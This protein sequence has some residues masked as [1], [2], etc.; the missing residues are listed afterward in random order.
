MTY[1]E[2]CQTKLTR[3]RIMGLKKRYPEFFEE[4]QKK[5]PNLPISEAI[6]KYFFPSSGKC[7]V[8]GK[9]TSY[10]GIIRGYSP[11]CSNSCSRKD[12]ES[13]ERRKNTSMKRYGVPIPSQSKIVQQKMEDTCMKRY[14]V[15]RVMESEEFIK[16]TKSN[17][18]KKYG[19]ESPSSLPHIKKKVEETNLKR[20]GVK[21]PILNEEIKNKIIKTTTERYGGMGNSS[22]IIRSRYENTCLCRYGSP[23]PGGL[24]DQQEKV[25]QTKLKRYGVPAYLP[26]SQISQ[27]FFKEIDDIF[28]KKY[29]TEFGDKNQEHH[30]YID[31][32][33]Y[34][35]DYYVQELNLDIEFQ[36]DVWHGNPEIFEPDDHCIPT[37]KSL[38]AKDL[39]Q[40]DQERMDKLKSIGITTIV[41]WESEYKKCKDFKQLIL[42]KL[43]QQNILI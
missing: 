27:K 1:Q 37:C 42:N 9:Q 7:K 31:G 41:V 4:L 21:V 40:K 24:P 15:K 28:N 11:Y 34:Y 12:P 43:K 17:N 3:T 13:E 36:G 38:T 18:L 5:F 29:H 25:K 30:I 39:W 20:Y 2:I 22:D 6:Y 19:V 33:N 14:G 16:R 26:I 8:C 23:N 10:K 32:K 35:L